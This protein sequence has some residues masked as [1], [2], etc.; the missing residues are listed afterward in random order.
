MM[1]TLISVV[2]I[3][4]LAAGLG[5][6][7]ET[8]T[9]TNAPAAT[10]TSDSLPKELILSK[11][12]ENAKDLLA[13]K[14]SA[15]EGEQVVIRGVIGGDEKPIAEN[16]A[17][18]MLLDPSVNTCNKTPGDGCTTPWDACC[19][20]KDTLVE[21]SASIQVVGAD[22]KPL[23]TGLAGVGGI[24]PLKT[25][26]VTGKVHGP[27]DGKNLLVDATGIFVQ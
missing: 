25:V 9:T 27:M 10:T 20:P 23:K 18:F 2:T 22:G 6:E 15:K 13:V 3:F 4:L 17:L 12:P 24:A 14:K 16:R 8:T 11:A 21:K 26:I 19:E 1:R 5:C 7:G